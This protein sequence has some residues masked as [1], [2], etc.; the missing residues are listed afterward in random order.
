MSE[1][2]TEQVAKDNGIQYNKKRLISN[3]AN[4][5][6]N[7]ERS[8]VDQLYMAHDL[9]PTTAGSA[10]EDIWCRM[11]EQIVPKKFVIESSVF[12]I[13]SN[14]YDDSDKDLTGVS[15]EVDLAIIDEMYTPYIFRYGKLKF[16]PIEAVAAVVECKST[17][18]KKEDLEAWIDRIDDLKT[19][20]RGIARTALNFP[21]LPPTQKKTKPLKI[22]C[23]LSGT[24][25]NFDFKI[26]AKKTDV[27][28]YLQIKSKNQDWTLEQWHKYLNSPGNEAGLS[29]I[30]VVDLSKYK[31]QNY[32]VKKDDEEIS[33]LTFNFQLNQ[34]LMIINNPILFPHRAYVK[35][36]NEGLGAGSKVSGG[37]KADEE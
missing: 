26:I 15:N 18:S 25:A 24:T 8:I 32:V 13:D 1:K 19:D 17:G 21:E 7:L 14:F 27:K 3:I 20:G 36:F 23:G 11:F 2:I 31:L 29:H 28:S 37:E 10:R 35:M 30:P 22:F 9:H 4:N 6:Q 34:L 16:V 5:Y 33:L 12:I